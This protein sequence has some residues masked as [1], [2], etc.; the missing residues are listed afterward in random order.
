MDGY[1]SRDGLEQVAP[2]LPRAFHIMAKPIGPLCNLD[3]SYCFYLRKEELYP[4]AQGRAWRMTEATL[5]AFIRQYMAAN[6][7]P[8]VSFAWQGGEPTLLGVEFFERAVALQRQYRRP[9]Q[10]VANALQTNGTLLDARWCEFLARE[11]FL[12]GLS[13]DGPPELHDHFRVDKGA[14]PTF[15]RVWQGRQQMLEAGVEHNILCVVNRRNET[16]GARVYDF[17][18]EAGVEHIQYIPATERG[19]EGTPTPWSCTPEGYGEFLVGAF[20]R[21]VRRDVGRVFVQAFD[22]ALRAW[23]GLQPGLC[24]N[25]E[26]CGDALALEHNGDVYSC[27]HFVQPYNHLGNLNDE[28]LADL[29]AS[30]FQRKFGTDKRDTLPPQCRACDVLFACGGGCPK[31]RWTTTAAG[32]PGLSYLCA[33]YLRFYH[34]IRPAMKFM[35]SE[36]RQGRPAAGVMRWQAARDERVARRGAS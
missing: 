4:A 33:G 32:D 15:E 36:L 5:E 28:P 7:G 27:D 34:H 24:V 31:E 11:R 23:C 6:Q 18:V 35:A 14:K 30:P 19:P 12:V 26:T 16:E 21:W 22:V 8:E 3:C 1:P 10:A 9:G 20:D 25:N 17:F 29:V 2:A 13:V